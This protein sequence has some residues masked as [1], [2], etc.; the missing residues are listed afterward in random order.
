[1]AWMPDHSRVVYFT[2]SGKLMIQDIGSLKRHEIEV[3]L[4]LPPDA[5]FNIVT[6]PDGRTIYYG[7]Q[8]TEANIWK[9]ERPKAMSK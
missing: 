3:R 9:A 5:D 4:P 6:S 7:A 1:M 8:Q 2:T